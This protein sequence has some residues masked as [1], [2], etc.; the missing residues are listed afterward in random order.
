M[1]NRFC[2]YCVRANRLRANIHLLPLLDDLTI[3]KSTYKEEIRTGEDRFLWEG[4]HYVTIKAIYR[5]HFPEIFVDYTDVHH[6]S[7]LFSKD[8]KNVGLAS[9]EKLQA[10]IAEI[11]TLRETE[12]KGFR[13][14]FMFAALKDLQSKLAG[15]TNETHKIVIVFE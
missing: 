6:Q 13:F 11:L 15:I 7:L 1:S 3:E 12:L 10:F 8:I 5:K 9:I 14:D 4:P 2:L